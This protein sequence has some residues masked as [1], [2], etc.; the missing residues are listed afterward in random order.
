M[1][2]VAGR[3]YDGRMETVATGKLAETLSRSELSDLA[4]CGLAVAADTTFEASAS[5]TVVYSVRVSKVVAKVLLSH[6]SIV[7]WLE[8]RIC[9]LARTNSGKGKGVRRNRQRT[10]RD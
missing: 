2:A 3:E 1:S 7:S 10:D 8:K 6:E 4:G 5:R 9:C